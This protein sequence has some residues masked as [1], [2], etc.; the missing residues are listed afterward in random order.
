MT[1]TE[2][3]TLLS[4]GE[5]AALASEIAGVHIGVV[6]F[7]SAMNRA[8]DQRFKGVSGPDKL[9]KWPSAVARAF[10]MSKWPA[11]LLEPDAARWGQRHGLMTEQQCVAAARHRDDQARAARNEPEL[12]ESEKY[13]VNAFRIAVSRKTR[14]NPA[15]DPLSPAEMTAADVPLQFVH[16]RWFRAH[17]YQ[18][19]LTN[20][21]GSGNR[22]LVR[23]AQL[24]PDDWTARRCAKEAGMRDAAEWHRH[25]RTHPR[26]RS[27]AVTQLGDTFIWHGPTVQTYLTST[28]LTGGSV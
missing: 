9:L 24:G 14:A 20:K 26:A 28:G 3:E 18:Q 7:R 27:L 6:T 13:S 2:Q 12:P 11:A 4:A 19:W 10:G 22:A 16:L 21:P 1:Y 5:A 23:N 17:E 25:C 15:P 8:K